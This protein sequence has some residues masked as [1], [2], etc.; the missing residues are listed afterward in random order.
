MTVDLRRIYFL[1]FRIFSSSQRKY[2]HDDLNTDILWDWVEEEGDVKMTWVE[3]K[4][5]KISVKKTGHLT[6]I[7][8]RRRSIVILK[9]IGESSDLP[10]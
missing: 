3:E 2:H 5:I 1:V 10:F 4:D 8:E 7:G 9:V 6:V